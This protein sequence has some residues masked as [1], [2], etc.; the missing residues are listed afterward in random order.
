MLQKDLIA[1]S[2]KVEGLKSKLDQKEKYELLL[3]IWRE[4]I[5]EY[6]FL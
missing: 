6:V 4:N 1:N 3:I 5:L 2:K